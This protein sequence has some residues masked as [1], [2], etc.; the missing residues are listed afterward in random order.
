MALITLLVLSCSEVIDFETTGQREFISIY[1]HF[2][3]GTLGNQV[4]IERTTTYGG[5]PRPI[6]G[7]N[8]SIYSE[9]GEKINFKEEEFNSGI[10]QKEVNGSNG[11]KGEA[12]YLEVVI[13]GGGTYRSDW[14]TLPTKGATDILDFEVGNIQQVGEDAITYEEYAVSLFAETQLTTDRADLFVKWDIESTWFFKETALPGQFW[15]WMWDVCY[16]VDK[17]EDQ[18]VRL[19]STADITTDKIPR[20]LLVTDRIDET[21]YGKQYYSL[22]QST[23]T[24]E[25]HDFWS[26]I[27]EVSNISGS[28]FD[29]PLGAVNSNITNISNENE[30]VLG[31]FEVAHVDT[32]HIEINRDDVN[33][34]YNEPC[35]IPLEVQNFPPSWF[36][37]LGRY[38]S[39]RCLDCLTIPNSS[40]QKPYYWDD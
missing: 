22:I 16:I 21:F 20:R 12:Y 4:T 36:N 32:T 3:D 19:F 23:I 11:V 15:W 26:G 34:F 17:L 38:F 40:L 9:A 35:V 33:L 24:K 14:Q 8:V 25:A 29:P 27:N 30:V 5:E 31:F 10:Y 28:I 7:A 1:G 18:E 6:S 2:N 37:R 39:E 13:P